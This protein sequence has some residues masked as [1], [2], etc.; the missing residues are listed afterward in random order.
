MNK[1]QKLL[2]LKDQCL[3]PELINGNKVEQIERVQ[4]LIHWFVRFADGKANPKWL[5]SH[6]SELAFYLLKNDTSLDID[7][8]SIRTK[9]FFEGVNITS[10]ERELLARFDKSKAL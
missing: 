4:E 1:E 6:A 5:K 2:V 9:G 8:E 7:F 3:K 10:D